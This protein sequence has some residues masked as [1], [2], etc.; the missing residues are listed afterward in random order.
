M[1]KPLAGVRVLDL[2]HW[3]SGPEATAALAA[4]GADVIKVE[5]VQRP[6]S[7]RALYARNVESDPNWYE[8]GSVFNGAN[9]GKRGI[10]L[11]LT[12]D[13]GRDVFKRL[14][15]TSDV[16]INNFSARVMSNLG[17]SHA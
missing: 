2:T 17:L 4:L 1:E 9:A 3:W 7:S 11:D 10:T 12:R 8:R 15:K 5:A 16:V 14:V 13:C 6:D